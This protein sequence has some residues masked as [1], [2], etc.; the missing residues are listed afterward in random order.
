LHR[1]VAIKVFLN[2]KTE[3]ALERFER[4]AVICTKLRHPNIIKIYD[5]SIQ[6]KLPK[7]VMEYIDSGDLTELMEKRTVTIDESLS[8][9]TDIGNALEY[10]HSQSILHRDLKPSNVMIQEPFKA[11]LMDFNLAFC[12]DLTMLTEEGYSVGTPQFM[13]PELWRGEPSSEKSDIFSL[14]LIFYDLLTGGRISASHI[15]TQDLQDR[16]IEPPSAYNPRISTDLES[17]ILWSVDTDP[18]HRCPSMK[19]FLDLLRD[20]KSHK[21]APKKSPETSNNLIVEEKKTPALPPASAAPL[22]VDISRR[23]TS[24]RRRNVGAAM[25]VLLCV[26]ALMYVPFSATPEMPPKA[27]LLSDENSHLIELAM[28]C[29]T[30]PLD[31]D[32]FN[33]FVTEERKL[34]AKN[35]ASAQKAENHCNTLKKIL[36]ALKTGTPF[37][38]FVESRFRL[39]QEENRQKPLILS[40]T[41]QTSTRSIELLVT[42]NDIYWKKLKESDHPLKNQDLTTAN[43]IVFELW[44]QVKENKDVSEKIIEKTVKCFSK[45]DTAIRRTKEGKALFHS[46][47]LCRLFH[48]R[49]C[50]PEYSNVFLL[51]PIYD[52]QYLKELRKSLI[53]KNQSI[54]DLKN[55]SDNFEERCEVLVTEAFT[56]LQYIGIEKENL[57]LEPPKR[58]VIDFLAPTWQLT[59]DLTRTFGG[60]LEAY[61]RQIH[62]GWFILNLAENRSQWDVFLMTSIRDC[63]KYSWYGFHH[64][65][66]R[67]FKKLGKLNPASLYF[68][69]TY[70]HIWRQA[71]LIHVDDNDF[72]HIAFVVCTFNDIL[73]ATSSLDDPERKAAFYT[74]TKAVEKK[75]INTGVALRILAATALRTEPPSPEETKA[76]FDRILK[77]ESKLRIEDFDGWAALMCVVSNDLFIHL[78][79]EKKNSERAL[80][81]VNL[82]EKI[83][84][85]HSD[86]KYIQVKRYPDK[87]ANPESLKQSTL[88]HCCDAYLADN[89][90]FFTEQTEL[91]KKLSARAGLEFLVS[92]K[93]L[94]TAHYGSLAAEK[95]LQNKVLG[96]EDL[97]LDPLRFR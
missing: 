85:Y 3:Y 30:E 44:Q 29:N 5:A 13:A 70:L 22:T 90:N 78:K 81:S 72:C 53:K 93:S 15:P 34:F 89:R 45:L 87:Y 57:K 25:A 21:A 43:L 39:R 69:R 67:Q 50:I 9:I 66:A 58:D 7:I 27:P 31:F 36:N 86:G 95:L 17:L 68:T 82:L 80:L 40:A 61:T 64:L 33:S 16:L 63:I 46:L 6:S 24:R 28:A 79:R 23:S 88:L 71:A 49:T 14:G 92:I 74:F 65:F 1:N 8:I 83:A 2:P 91:A 41:K 35:N 55:L 84:K 77:L 12:K 94:D 62:Q 54:E 51:K 19:Q 42:C 56:F 11:I 97:V 59:D 26:F 96:F 38:Y 18:A 37:C 4:E 10:L 20:I 48:D 60:I 32:S 47:V 73:K 75:S 76:A 52:N